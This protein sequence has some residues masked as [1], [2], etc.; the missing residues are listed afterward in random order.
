LLCTGRFASGDYYRLSVEALR[1]DKRLANGLG[2]PVR[3]LFLDLG[4]KNNIIALNQAQVSKHFNSTI[5]PVIGPG[6]F[7]VNIFPSL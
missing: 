7:T 1:N 2:P 4:N 5:N 6:F 3:S